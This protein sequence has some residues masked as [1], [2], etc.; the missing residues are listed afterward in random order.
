MSKRHLES[1]RQE[2][3]TATA[4]W[5]AAVPVSVAAGAWSESRGCDS[6]SCLARS[7]EPCEGQ[8]NEGSR[9]DRQSWISIET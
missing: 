2:K 9:S 3:S 8:E 7:L 1:Q 4:S 6:S 5:A